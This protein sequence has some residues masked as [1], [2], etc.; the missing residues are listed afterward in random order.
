[1]MKIILLLLLVTATCSAQQTDLDFLIE[2]I[3]INYPG[4]AEKTRNI[5]FDKFVDQTLA[6]NNADTFK[7]MATIVDFFHDRHLDL[8]QASDSIDRIACNHSLE[9]VIE[10]TNLGKYKMLEGFW[11]SEANHCVIAMIQVSKKPIRYKAYVVECRDSSILYPGM[12]YYELDHKTDSQFFTKCISSRDRRSFYVWSKFRSDTLFTAG[13]YNK[14]KK[15]RHYK[16]P[17]LSNFPVKNDMASGRRLSQETFLL[18]IPTSTARNGEIVDSLIRANKVA[19]SLTKNLIIDIR[20]NTGGT[21]LAYAPLSPLLYTNPVV[22]VNSE[23]YGTADEATKIEKDVAAYVAGGGN[24][25]AYIKSWLD[26]AK[27]ERDSAGKFIP[28]PE[29]TMRLDAVLSYPENVGIIIN[30]GCQSAS[31]IFLLEAM[32][33]KKVRL[34]GEHTMGAIDYLDYYPLT[35]PSGRYKIYIATTRRKLPEGGKR[36]DSIGIQPNTFID[37]S[38]SN[39]VEVV[40]RY[41]EN[42]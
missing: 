37:D 40:K 32:Q 31:E 18:T 15:L 26:F 29:D 12:V 41:Y 2:K 19:L 33:S 3:K 7:A 10:Y 25:S 38:E 36:L 20:N 5:D 1:M 9:K 21:V 34:F 13:P 30:Y 17:I 6:K 8:F 27:Q 11:L 42:N 24:D 4:Y 23:V 35:S 16:E 39:W 14:W 28:M 22:K